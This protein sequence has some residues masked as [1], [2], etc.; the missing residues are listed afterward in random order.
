MTG[1]AAPD[2]A[3]DAVIA[4]ARLRY[5]GDQPYSLDYGDIYHAPDGHA[6]VERVFVGPCGLVELARRRA[7]RP[8]PARWVRVAEL[9]FGSGLNF[10]VAAEACL[11]AGAN[12][13]FVS[14]EAHPIDA[15]DLAA[16]AAARAGR[17]PL[18]RELNALYPPRLGGW[19]QR[20][21]AGGRIRLNLWLGDAAAGL[22]DMAERQRQPLDAWFLDGFAPDRNPALWQPALFRSVAALSGPDTRVATFTAAGRVRRGLEAAGFRMRRVDQRPH[23]RESLAG[24][25]AGRG[26]SGWTPP[27]EVQVLG[28]GLAGASAA[29]HLS[30]A[31]I[32][33]RVHDA[34]DP[35]SLPPASRIPASVLHARLLADG[36]AT[37]ALRC[38]AYLYAAALVRQL[39]GFTAAGTLQVAGPSRAADKLRAV[40]ERYAGSGSWVRYLERA[41]AAG[42]AAWP[43]PDGALWL[44]DAGSVDLPVLVRGLL[45]DPG[46][47][48][49][50]LPSRPSALPDGPVILACGAQTRAFGEA[51]YLELAPVQGQVDLVALDAAPSVPLVGNGYLV[52][53]EGDGRAGQRV[54]LGSTY[55]YQP[56]GEDRATASNLTQLAGRTHRWLGRF[57]GTRSVSSDRT[58]IAGPLYDAEGRA[59]T[60]RFVTT[61]HGSAGNVS[62]HLAAALLAARISGDCPPLARPLEAALSPLRFRERQARRGFRHGAQPD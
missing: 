25:F 10:V 4:P 21:L 9:G 11:A 32:A 51:A 12:L 41:E 14:F 53:L 36:S 3:P 55:E 50:L 61:G 18:Y 20:L 29:W 22:A 13:H 31:G 57:R 7:R 44:P 27:S 40:A 1:S 49:E 23:K 19:H 6:E 62:A 46:A 48:L 15:S 56:W 43:V 26:L 45:H 35:Q 59:L 30:R 16:I 39:P 47:L 52:P 42:R 37:A 54:A 5:A 58:A 2:P 34:P 60:D 38:Q 28:A 8:G 17:H 33:V 24:T